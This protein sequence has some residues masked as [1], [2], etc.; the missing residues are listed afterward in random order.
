[1]SKPSPLRV[2]RVKVDNAIEQSI[3]ASD[4]ATSAGF[5]MAGLSLWK[6]IGH[7]WTAAND[8][9][10]VNRAA[11]L[12]YYFL[13]A[14]FP[15][16]I[17]IS[18]MFGMFASTR[19]QANVELMLYLSKVIPAGA[20]GLV[21]TTLASTTRA[22]DATKIL[23]G[24]LTAL[25]S[26][27]YG[28]SS[29]QS[30]LNVVYRVKETRPYWKSKLIAMG[31]MLAIFVLVFSAMLLLLLGDY[32]IKLAAHYWLI[33][34]TLL[35]GWRI[36]RIVASLFFLSL[37]FSLTYHLGPDRKKHHWRWI[38]PGAVVGIAGWL[39]VS[40]GFRVYLHFFNNYAVLYGSFGTVI[41]LLTWF[42]VSGLMLLLGAEINAAIER[43]AKEKQ[44][45]QSG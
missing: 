35:I 34:G 6:L 39:G 40:I 18:A 23:F 15:A 2:E 36:V 38:S 3:R 42:Y 26:A 27:T 14:L 1:M 7:V 9:D 12:A 20:F 21:E 45:M 29:A 41:V 11:E 44:Q 32:I 13:F 22:S 10:I 30:I 28:M 37:V 19:T 31:L 24:A 4:H 16:L 33:S 8:D 43:A 17:F 5:T 25:W